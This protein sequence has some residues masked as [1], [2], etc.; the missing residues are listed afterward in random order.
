MAS[1]VNVFAG[2]GS[3]NPQWLQ[4]IT[5]VDALV[6]EITAYFLPGENLKPDVKCCMTDCV[7]QRRSGKVPAQ[8]TP[9]FNPMLLCFFC[10]RVFHTGCLDLDEHLIKEESVPWKCNE[11]KSDLM[12]E[13]CRSYYQK[14]SYLTN[15][16]ERRSRF[17]I[18][19][20]VET[21]SSF[22]TELEFKK[23][24][25]D[26]FE[27][28]AKQILAEED[29]EVI[30]N[31]KLITPY[32]LKRVMQS[33]ADKKRAKEVSER[34][35]MELERA[36]AQIRAT[37]MSSTQ[38]HVPALDV[39]V[40][41]QSMSF[42]APLSSTM[43]P[44]VFGTRATNVLA[45]LYTSGNTTA[46]IETSQRHPHSVHV[47]SAA[48]TINVTS[49]NEGTYVGLD[50]SQNSV[51]PA[52][53]TTLLQRLTVSQERD[54]RRNL[55]NI[56]RRALPKIVEFKGEESKWLAFKQDV[57]R[58]RQHLG[59]DEIALKYHIKSALKG[60]AFEIVRDLFDAESLD[61]IMSTL[62][63]AFG[64]EMRMVRNRG[65]ELRN[66]KFNSNL[67]RMDAI[68]L[69]SAMQSYFAACR[70]ANIGYINTNTIAEA[71]F[72]QFNQEDRLRCRDF[73]VQKN[74]EAPT[75][76]MDVQTIYEYL[77]K[78]IPLLDDAPAKKKSFEPEQKAKSK[79]YQVQTVTVPSPKQKNK[80]DFKFEIKDK[81]TAPYIGYDLDKVAL[82][83]QECIFCNSNDHYA[84][85][86][87]RFKEK[88]EIDRLKWITDKGLCK[89]CIITTAHRAPDCDL[90][91]NCGYRVDKTSRCCSRHHISIHDASNNAQHSS[92]ANNFRRK[93]TNTRNNTARAT[94]R[95]NNARNSNG[96][97][98]AN[99]GA[100]FQSNDPKE[101]KLSYKVNV[102]AV[103]DTKSADETPKTVKVF[104]VKLWGPNGYVVAIV[105]GDSGSEITLMREDLR[106]ALGIQGKPH[107]L[108]LQWA[109][110]TSRTSNAV[111]L[112]MQI[113]SLEN[114]SIKLDLNNCFALDDLY[115]PAR[116][117]DMKELRKQFPYLTNIPF[118]GYFNEH[119]VMLIGAP[120]AHLIEGCELVEGG[121]N[122]PIAVRTRIGWSVY[123]GMTHIGSSTE[124][125]KSVNSL[126][127]V[128]SETDDPLED[129]VPEKKK[130]SNEMLHELLVQHFS[131]ESLG[132]RATQTHFTKDEKNA[133]EILDEE[134]IVLEGG[135]VEAPLVWKR[136]NKL[137]PRLPNNYT[138]VLQRQLAEERKLRKNPLHLEAYNNNVKE[139]I[140]LN[141]LREANDEDM[142]GNWPNVWYLPTSLVINA[143]K[144]PPKMRNV[145]DASAI[146]RGT[147]LNAN[148]L[149]GPDLLI[150]IINP[151]IRMRMNS[152]A[153]TADVKAMFNMVKI[154]ARDTQ[155]QRIL[156]REDHDSPMKTFIATVMLFGPTSSPFTSQY[157]KNKT[158]EK[159]IDKYPDA[160]RTLIDLTYMD[161]VLTSEPSID[162]A[163]QVATQCIEIC[164]SINWKLVAFQ[165]NS[166]EL[167]SALPPNAVKQEAIP[168]P[169]SEA[170]SQV[171]KVLG[172]QWNT[173]KD[174]LEF[175]LENNL[176]IQL[177]K[178]FDQKPSKRDQASTLARI[179][180]VL[181]LISHFTIRGKILLQRS[182]ADKVG[183]DDTISDKAA[184]DW[185]N[186][187]GQISDIAKLEFPRRF[188]QL[189]ALNDAEEIHLHIFSDAGAE[190][191]GAV[192]Y[193]VIKANGIVDSSIVMA[194]AKVTPLR[195]KTETAVKEMPRLEMMAALIAARLSKT[196]T[197]AINNGRM[198][199][200]FWCDSEVV[201]RWILN[202]N[203]K[204]VKY[205]IG[206]IE[207]ILEL[208]DRKEWN[209][210]PTELNAADLCTKMKK[211]DFSCNESVWMKGPCFIK[212]DESHWP[213]L[214]IKL[215]LN[216]NVMVG[217]IYLEKF[218][219]S[220]HVLPPINCKMASDEAI[221]RFSA[222]IKSTWSKTKRAT[223]RALKLHMD[224]FI[225]LIQY[226]LFN[227]VKMI[228]EMKI[229]T[230]NMNNLTTNDFE[231]AE[232]FI[233]RK[234]QREAFPVEYKALSEGK[235]IRNPMMQ[236]LNVFL[237][238][239]GLI[240]INARVNAN[241]ETYPQQFAPLLPRRN[242]YVTNLLAYYHYK[243][244]H[245]STEA[246]IAEIRT[247]AWI[248]ELKMALR[249]IK[250]KCNW[251]KIKKAMPYSPKMAPLPEDRVNAD[252]KPFEVTGID[253]LGPLRPTVNGNIKK[254]YIL[255]FVCTLTRYIHLHILDSMESLRILEAIVTFWTSYGP[256]RKFI[257]DNAS[258]FKRTAKTLE[259]D[260]HREQFFN[261]H[262]SII[263]PKLSE[264][265]RV[266]WQFIPAHSPWFGGVYERL[267]KEVKRSLSV[268]LER[269][270]ITR[271][272]LNIAVMEATHRI[273]CRPL[274]EN[275]LDAADGEI[276]TPHHLVKNKSGWPLL[277]GIHKNIYSTIPDRSI[278]K[279]GRIVADELMRQFTSR[280]LPILTKRTK[281]HKS[282]P[283]PRIGDLVLVIEPNKTR[284]E[285]QRAKIIKI[286]LGKDG[287]AR[288]ADVRMW[289]G[290]VKKSR[291]IRN[292][293][294]L[295]ISK[296]LC[297][298]G[299]NKPST[300]SANVGAIFGSSTDFQ[301]S[302]SSLSLTVEPHNNELNAANFTHYTNYLCHSRP[303]NLINYT[304]KKAIAAIN[305]VTKAVQIDGVSTTMK[306]SEIV[307]ALEP[308]FKSIIS[309]FR[310]RDY[311]T[312]RDLDTVFVILMDPEE[313]AKIVRT[314]R[315]IS[316]KSG[317]SISF[318]NVVLGSAY[319][320]KSLDMIEP[321]S[322]KAV[323]MPVA[324][325]DLPR[326]SHHT[327]MYVSNLLK[328][329]EYKV[330]VSGFRW[331]LENERMLTRSFGFLTVATQQEAI[332]L[333]GKHY[334]VAEDVV[335]AKLSDSATILLHQVDAY[336][337]ND[338][339]KAILTDN[340]IKA[341]WLNFTSVPAERENIK[342][343][344]YQKPQTSQRL[345][346]VIVRPPQPVALT[347][348]VHHATSSKEPVNPVTISAPVP[349]SLDD[350]SIVITLDST[351]RLDDEPCCS[352]TLMDKNN[353]N[354]IREH[355]TAILDEAPAKKKPKSNHPTPPGKYIIWR[356]EGRYPRF[357]DFKEDIVDI[358]KHHEWILFVEKEDSSTVYMQFGNTKDASKFKDIIEGVNTHGRCEVTYSSDIAKKVIDKAVNKEL[359]PAFP[360]E[361]MYLI[362]TERDIIQCRYKQKWHKLTFFSP[363][364]VAKS[365]K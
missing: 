129:P 271:V 168:L 142:I 277:P 296:S 163:L 299:T 348:V 153:F 19:T 103:R 241:K 195:L 95:V 122:G 290:K 291:A 357:S 200:S 57:D 188:T 64:D 113:Q 80:G 262:M 205:A 100:A 319:F 35:K 117:L 365:D 119:P 315:N 36:Q 109:D 282:D 311:S 43:M 332:R 192:A 120:H 187:L 353:Y 164:D 261:K 11:C 155:C 323:P 143:N 274:T 249:S 25:L 38:L 7:I 191:F 89:N 9:E 217:N 321:E 170:E 199:R 269:R 312:G 144:N 255:I 206:P 293:A 154:C 72:S 63:I 268:T 139:L 363:Q 305:S 243:H 346:S 65:E 286:H 12:N 258:N 162:K 14:S 343:T 307:S 180:D 201:L 242:V 313:Y 17:L 256:V 330:K 81:V 88:N 351:E 232:H 237:D 146:Y 224:V 131:V 279:R 130:I 292:L 344:V 125:T 111:Q 16:I 236:Q 126:T 53:F 115:L 174:C 294:K 244:N 230:D 161:D 289:N 86:C 159:W 240:R 137:I 295:D 239:Q 69:Q 169:E 5:N 350:D 2:D 349:V 70:Y 52:D 99:T 297:E 198:K 160:A 216:D 358:S 28:R 98:T 48:P 20:I 75:I 179:Y 359:K 96:Q 157:V 127:E 6:S 84:V 50:N 24:D 322:V 147:S 223:A 229:I 167:L 354:E 276:L 226:K 361:S 310:K 8:S 15:M 87:P 302:N 134:V 337:I 183:W 334:I 97:T 338:H 252:M 251:C 364:F 283:L 41:D 221:D 77:L 284:K 247:L 320:K 173:T 303:F 76:V 340:I 263:G 355:P 60:E 61:V 259:E 309:I 51:N 56:R 306:L 151:L 333:A 212:Q 185:K 59:Q 225:P 335:E 362:N 85:Q 318:P 211:F 108:H 156:F 124:S 267:I 193:L 93:R 141:Y 67:Y 250:A 90:K 172:C 339:R 202:P 104:R 114:K 106:E 204:L 222:S 47:N 21:E 3:I 298:E 66:F 138:A 101:F 272:E 22:P 49:A 281:W 324:L 331:C 186:W 94:E 152:I 300:S 78:R 265:Y 13:P 116:T 92:R 213:K 165:S 107:T 285:W 317:I 82:V 270:K 220:T 266:E 316:L 208:T 194:K 45:N 118:E 314:H 287:I 218:N 238:P 301:N 4:H 234:I 62:K 347:K 260:F 178:D 34:F 264:I 231:R 196:I 171:T 356:T 133:V 40:A 257:S 233:F 182:W 79:S 278:Y 31:P 189:D 148:L 345:Q 30:K 123:G 228:R 145:Y 288:V 18:P 132:I 150:N 42:N 158:A 184:N 112:N 23:A 336:L 177:V 58:Y 32:V 327:S 74:P 329:F 37:A 83:T 26:S 181:G 10:D 227:N 207:E 91:S 33:R 308:E 245:I 140:A 166:T 360:T 110:K 342:I 136:V 352:R 54:E 46:S 149:K 280:Y 71:I 175:K 105:I 326:M 128:D 214:P 341:N 55:E 121:N 209:Y 304:M 235:A 254:V 328:T 248:P 197:N 190:A 1:N 135:F 325:L 246:Q 275:P 215:E 102:G 219:Y 73:Y 27:R 68:K 44:S 39:T 29:P 203:H 253:I 273:N 210:V 176:F